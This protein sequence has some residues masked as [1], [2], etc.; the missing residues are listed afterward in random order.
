MKKRT[1]AIFTALAVFLPLLAGC[2]DDKQL[3]QAAL[4]SETNVLTV[5]GVRYLWD[6]S[7]ITLWSGSN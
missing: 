6:E 2:Q 4:D 1:I 7:L 3:E 5:D